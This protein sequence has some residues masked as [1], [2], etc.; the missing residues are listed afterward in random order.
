[1]TRGRAR[2]E[3]RCC[4]GFSGRRKDEGIVHEGEATRKGERVIE[5]LLMRAVVNKSFA[6]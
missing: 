5:G 6:A 4:E 1:M 3:G 2:E